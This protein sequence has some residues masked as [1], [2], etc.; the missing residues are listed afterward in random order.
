MRGSRLSSSRCTRDMRVPQLLPNAR[1]HGVIHSAWNRMHPED[2][3][4]AKCDVDLG[5]RVTRF[6]LHVVI[7]A[8][9]DGNFVAEQGDKCGENKFLRCPDAGALQDGR[10]FAIGRKQAGEIP[11]RLIGK[12]SRWPEGPVNKL[13]LTVWEAPKIRSP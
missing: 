6:V 1:T 7:T 10:Q 3:L 11:R 9:I 13:L 2:V 5:H 8:R 4:A 12:H